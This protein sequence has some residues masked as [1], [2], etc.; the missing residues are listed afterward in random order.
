MDDHSVNNE[1]S[2]IAAPAPEEAKP[3]GASA[4]TPEILPATN[5]GVIV[6]PRERTGHQISLHW[7]AV[8]VFINPKVV[9]LLSLDTLLGNRLANPDEWNKHF[10]NTGFSGRRY[11]AIYSGPLDIGLYG[12]PSVGLHCHLEI[13]GEACEA[14]GQVRLFEFL[15]SLNEIEA[16]DKQGKPTG[17]LAK[18]QARRIDIAIDG[19]P[20]TPRQCYEAVLRRDIRSEAHRDSYKWF[21]N[22]EGDTLY[23]GSRASG[24][25]VRIYNRRGPTR[26]EMESKGRWAE[27]VAFTIANQAYETFESF[28]AS[29]LRQFV[30]FVEADKGGSITRAPLLPWWEEFVGQVA[31]GAGQPK[32][33]DISGTLLTRNKAYLERLLP[34][35]LVIR[36][37]LGVSLDELVDGSEHRLTPKHLR[38]IDELQRALG[39]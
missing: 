5:R 26:V 22:A 28:A 12:Y 4:A 2:A 15:E 33:P 32:D 11:K 18:W 30:D 39:F 23:I 14:I 6:A 27:Y 7:L 24:R 34:S 13:K 17:E 19:A 35:L 1:R 3:P 8:T 25:L 36:K 10:L 20:F 16:V 21:S 9:A 38:K 29:Y 31:K 37:G